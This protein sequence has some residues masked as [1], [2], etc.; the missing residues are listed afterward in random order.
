M[1]T[2]R[3]QII[4]ALQAALIEI[5]GTAGYATNFGGRVSIGRVK[6]WEQDELPAINLKY[7]NSSPE[8]TEY[9]ST[10]GPTQ[11]WN[12]TLPV[13][14]TIMMDDAA[15]YAQVDD[16]SADVFRKIGEDDKF[17]ISGVEQTNPE[18]EQIADESHEEFL[19]R[20]STINVNIHYRTNQWQ[21]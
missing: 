12:K 7:A 2:I 10:E 6:P 19:Y 14:I 21:I 4:E 15:T 5:N 17:G 18:S 13:Q 3:T 8:S 1:S 20:G 16:A 11:L 9:F